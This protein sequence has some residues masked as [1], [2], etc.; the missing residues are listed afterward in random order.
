VKPPTRKGFGTTIIDRSIPYDLGGAAHV[1]YKESGVEAHFR[2][3]A[4]HVS[5]Q[6][7]FA[8]PR[9]KYPRAA[10]GHAPIL[11]KQILAG[12]KMLLV[13]DS[14]IIALD[15]EDIAGRLGA[16]SVSTAATVEGALENIDE[17]LP[18]VAMLDIN[19][20]DRTSFVVAD[21]LADLNVPFIFATGYG[22]QAQL[23]E[24]H[25]GRIV[26]Q[27]PYTLENIARAVDELLS[28]DPAGQLPAG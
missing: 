2:I 25:R 7:N 12:Q 19:L 23:P 11:P 4:R 10:V 24:Q 1:D 28:M 6:K 26:V 15:A 16:A 3:P 18:T 20:G 8:G 5:E 21:R 13:E 14:L 27:K 9:I 17:D 22:E